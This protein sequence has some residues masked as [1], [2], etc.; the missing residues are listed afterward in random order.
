[1]GLMPPESVLTTRS[2]LADLVFAFD[3]DSSGKLDHLVL[4][5]PEAGR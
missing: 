4:Y 3:Y 2:P 5:R 1:M